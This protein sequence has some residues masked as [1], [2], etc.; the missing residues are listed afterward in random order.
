MKRGVRAFLEL[1]ALVGTTALAG[2]GCCGPILLQWLG[3][4]LWAIGGRVLL[5]ALLRFEVP[6]LLGVAA[7]SLLG[8]RLARD[9]AARLGN[10]VLAGTTLGLAALRLLWDM[11][12]GAVMAIGPLYDLF[13]Y[14]QTALAVA[15]AGVLALRVA[16]LLDSQLRWR[17]PGRAD[18]ACDVAK[19]STE[20]RDSGLGA[21]SAT[22]SRTPARRKGLSLH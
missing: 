18:M 1:L 19:P 7:L 15:G 12:R 21:T 2:A 13:T 16:A 6:L 9:R 20:A 17:S 8:R 10:T 4:A 5:A 14:R 11:D 22:V 3:L